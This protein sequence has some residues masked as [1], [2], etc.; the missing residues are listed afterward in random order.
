MNK[1]IAIAI[2]A[3]F[4]SQDCHAVLR[5]SPQIN[6]MQEF[7]WINATTTTTVDAAGESLASI[8][9]LDKSK[10]ITSIG[11]RTST[12][13][14][15]PTATV[16]IQTVDGNFLPTGVAYGGAVAGTSGT[17]KSNNFFDVDLGGNATAT[18][19]DIV[20]VMVTYNSGTSIQLTSQALTSIP[21]GNFPSC[22]TNISGSWAKLTTSRPIVSIKYS[23]G[24]YANVGAIPLKALAT[25]QGAIFTTST[26]DEVATKFKIPYKARFCGLRSM[27]RQVT[28]SSTMQYVLYDS[29]GTNV[30]TSESIAANQF[31]NSGGAGAAWAY[32]P[33]GTK[34]VI[35]PGVFYYLSLKPTTDTPN[36]ITYQMISVDSNG[37]F[38]S[39]SG[40]RNVYFSSR[41]DAGS[42]NDNT[43]QRPIVLPEF[44]QLDDGT[45]NCIS[46]GN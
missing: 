2:L 31:G 17:L 6:I 34:Q 37:I 38:D 45:V 9:K 43:A 3:L 30:I 5:D 26:P 28:T 14:G 33:F 20:A 42:W 12:V 35:N 29:T 27:V 23:D 7:D 41:T 11:F 39:F 10:T 21:F 40:G 4:V 24:T 32:Y 16:T 18:A 19:G 15:S 13:A 36:T 22:A 46:V 1:V 44:D 25:Q 8:V